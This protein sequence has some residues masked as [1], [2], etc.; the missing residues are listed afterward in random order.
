[1]IC[2]TLLLLRCLLPLVLCRLLLLLFQCL[3]LLLL[4]QVDDVLETFGL[5][6]TGPKAVHAVAF[7][8]RGF[9]LFPLD[10]ENL[11]ANAGS[12]VTAAAFVPAGLVS[13]HSDSSS[14][15]DE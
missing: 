5:A 11:E 1:M 7:D 9:E 13:D 4:L 8:H 3:Y 2:T 12:I 15:S 6:L 10:E 14:Q